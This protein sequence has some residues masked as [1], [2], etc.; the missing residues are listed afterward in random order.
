MFRFTKKFMKGKKKL[1][2]LFV[3]LLNGVIYSQT[4]IKGKIDFSNNE[5]NNSV[6]IILKKDNETIEYTYSDSDNN[7]L[8]ETDKYGVFT[9]VFSSL[10]FET[11]SIN[12]EITPKTQVIEKNVLLFY[13]PI[14]LNEVI[15]E[16]EKPITIKNDTIVFKAKSFLQGNEE[17]VE[18]LLK[19]I[20]GLNV[21]T[22]GTIKIGNQEV[23]KI[24][25]DGDDM[26]EK[27]YK[28]L[29]KNMPVNPID[30][31]EIYQNY[32]NNKQ[33]KGIENSDK[34]ALNLTLKEDYKRVW[35]GNSIL[36]YGLI[37]ENRY[38]VKSNL[39][40]FGK[41]AKYYFI[42]NLNNTGEDVTGDINNLI[43]PYRIDEPASIGDNQSVKTLIGLNTDSPSL[44]LKRI[45]FNNAEL[46]SLNSLFSLSKKVKLKSIVFLNT[47][48][49]DFFKNSIQSFFAGTNYFTNV[50]DYIDRKKQITGFGKIDLTYDISNTS[51][52][53]YSG[54]FN[55]LN[56][57]N[58]SDL[59]FNNNLLNEK[60][61]N[62]NQLID[63]KIVL[64]NRLKENKVLVL[65]GRYINEKTPQ[66]Y[67][68][69]Q[70]I[71]ND[72][73]LE[74]ANN[75]KQY[76]QNQMQFAGI[77]AHL[78]DRKENENLLEIKTGNQLRID[79][80]NTLFE[81]YNNDLNISSPDNYKNNLKYITNDYYLSTKYLFKLGHYKILTQTDFHKL[82]NQIENYE[83]KKNQNPFYIIPK[84]GLD[85][86]INYKNKIAT[87]YSY[88]T[89]N[90][91]ILDI[92]S[93]YVQ[94]GFRSFSKGLNDFNQLSSS[95]AIIN[96]T[97]GGWG[98]K[99]FA[100]TFV[101]YSK[102]N[103]FYSNNS[104]IS[105][106]YSQIE[107]V[108][109]KDRNLLS[110][111]SNVDYYFKYIKSNLKI[112]LSATKTNFKNIINNSN[113]REVTNLS[114]EYGFEIRS[115][116][117]GFFNYHLG[118]KWNYNNVKATTENSFSNNMSFLDLLLIFNTKFNVEIQSER[119]FFGN[120]DKDSN[121]YYFLDAE[122]RYVVKENKLTFFLSANNLFNTQ[123]FRNYNV[124]DIDISKIEYKLQPR[125]ILLKME[126]RF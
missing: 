51:M 52:F 30:K 3:I 75:T 6:S 88:T 5:K 84:I 33:L 17:V 61:N 106:N 80:L 79:N 24:M 35:F 121:Q 91:G 94:T 76:S 31:I 16:A 57:K 42:T 77:E 32:S 1:I 23:E 93:A 74:N 95:N 114:T 60:L 120:L 44:K 115:G 39:M 58:N 89:T 111:S 83:T 45:N 21:T 55:L 13:Q 92:Y 8:L 12:I 63:Q 47:N 96:Y 65:S 99:F 54:K 116:F 18:D 124:S 2:I 50:E 110:I 113:L 97:Y 27:G 29:T 90:A 22:D 38:D 14:E 123:T 81:L 43:R 67:S 72:L 59:L 126:Y 122:A 26:F 46:L 100:N 98:E 62:N 107:K 28:I 73:F 66:K 82:F 87:S 34:V 85:W 105:Q 9:L 7:Y 109:F 103:D 64:T 117:K 11:K 37:S 20:P 70:F 118:S 53:E 25:I 4:R 104:V 78:L 48:E 41:K 125:Y 40:N 69:N 108:I 36:G 71:F 15:I 68:V 101:L 19:K 112:N 86:D 119:Y 56:E 10:S 102:N 49:T